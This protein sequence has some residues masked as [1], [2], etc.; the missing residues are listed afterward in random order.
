MPSA[1]SWIWL[2]IVVQFAGYAFDVLW[3]GVLRPG[4]EPRTVDE[5]MRHLATVHL[6][7]YIGA[8]GLLV[9]TAAALL[10]R[11]RQRTAGVALLVAFG[12]ALLSTAAEAWHAISHL[13]MDTH[14]GPVAGSLS[15]VGLLTVVVAMALSGRQARRASGAGHERRAA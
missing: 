6:P 3:H 4:A 14:M 7:L 12:G 13:R 15:F 11:G 9:A 8:V 10:R 5:M 1:R 2:A